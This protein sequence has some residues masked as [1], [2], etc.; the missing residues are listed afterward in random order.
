MSEVAARRLQKQVA[1]GWFFFLPFLPFF[2]FPSLSP[3]LPPTSC[4]FFSAACSLFFFLQ[5]E[6][7]L[8]AASRWCLES[9]SSFGCAA[10]SERR[11]QTAHGCFVPRK[12]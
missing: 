2:I 4:P 9:L 12:K 5:D 6:F 10:G 1:L 7:R 3:R 8:W 11:G